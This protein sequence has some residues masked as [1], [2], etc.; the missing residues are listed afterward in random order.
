MPNRPAAAPNIRPMTA[1]AARPVEWLWPGWIPLGKVAVL[2]GDPGVGKS[3]LLFDLAARLSRDGALPDGAVS[4]VG[5]S[6]ILS[7]ED[8]EADTIKPRLAAAGGVAERLFTLPTVTGEDGE[9]R[10]PELPGDLSAVES[11][12]AE[13]GV[14]LLVID[15][16]MAFLTRV[17]AS[18]D[19][20]VRRALHKLTRVAERQNCAV[21]CLRHLNRFGDK[22][23]YRGGGSVGSVAA[24]RSGLLVATD[25]DDPQC[26]LLAATKCN[27]AERPRPLRFRLEARDG[28]CT[29]VW[30]GGA[31]FK[32]DDL[33]RK[34][35]H[36]EWADREEVRCLVQEAMHFL[37]N[38]LAHG[39]QPRSH[40]YL[41][42]LGEGYSRRTME[43]A[44]KALGLRTSFAYQN[45]SGEASYELPP[46]PAPNS[47]GGL[48]GGS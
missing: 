33:V 8:G 41:R 3:T 21:V 35:S 43:R 13:H 19:Q 18:R 39:P 22:A 38:L 44:V 12:V 40:C 37:R 20:D 6:L 11:A 4:K 28:V 15:P 7:A 10:P 1:V 17:D 46:D 31:D 9:E 23:I 36:A 48:A 27:L 34:M 29:V 16:L 14:R 45:A 32:A 42:G 5:A 25:P 47:P 2:D 30:H 24:A 26:R